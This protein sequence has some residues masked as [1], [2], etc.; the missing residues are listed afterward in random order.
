MSGLELFLEAFHFLRPWW[1]AL[2]PIVALLWWRVRSLRVSRDPSVDQIAPH[3]R[4]ALTVGKSARSRVQPIDG[5]A[6]ALVLAAL[7]AAGPTWSRMPD[8]FVAQSA[9]LVIA[10]EVTTQMEETDIAPSRLERGKQKIRDLLTL[11]AGARTALIAYAGSAH[12]VV[13]M[14]DDPGVMTPYL[15]GLTPDVMPEDGEVA[16]E[17]LALATD[18]LS[19]EEVPGGVLFVADSVDPADAAA[20]SASGGPLVT[21]LAMLPGGVADRG[22]DALSV[23]VIRVTPDEGDIRQINQMLDAAFRRAMLE[24]SDQPWLDRGYLL[25]WPLA[26]LALL[27]FRRGWTMR[28]VAIAGLM[29][30]SGLPQPASAGVIDWFLTPDQQGRLAF[31]RRE[32]ARAAELFVDPLWRGYA[33]YRDGQYEEAVTVL[34]RVETAQAAFIQGMAQ[35]K[36]RAYRDGVRSF[37]TTLERDPDYPGAAENLELSREIVDY[38]ET[39]REQSDTGEE[40][41]IGADEVVLDN[42][43]NR[44]AD[45]EM[46]APQEE[47]MGLMTTD[48]WM[49]TVDTRTGD[50]LRQRF[51]IEQARGPAAA[52]EADD[53]AEE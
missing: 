41:G 11:R 3:L 22:L 26:L 47:G 27:W 18:I 1:L 46:Q 23:P 44:G 24:N 28:W 7:G 9:P 29:L 4:E 5:V 51:A 2:L 20:L 6:V 52:T 10:L 34:D 53:G 40:T 25:A 50:F 17:A 8:P 36:S 33:L 45:T 30:G 37:E 35:M 42:E 48:Q 38:V 49:Q 12:R 31:E 19:R 13:P 32:Y 39:A 21:V 14:T 15:S 43:A 16:A